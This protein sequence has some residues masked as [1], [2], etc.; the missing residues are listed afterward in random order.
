MAW[1]RA[2]LAPLAIAFAAGIAA[3]PWV[4][5]TAAWVAGVAA[6]VW[7]T[8]LVS[9]GRLGWASAFLL[10]GVAAAGVLR[11]TPLPP[12][13]DHVARLALPVAARLE[14]RLAREPVRFAPERTRLLV[15]AERVD[16]RPASG[17][18]QVTVYGPA[19]DL[20]E[21]QRVAAILRL[22][23]ATGFRNP[24]GFDHARYLARQGIFVVG[25]ADAGRLEALD[26]PV[27]PWPARA[28]RAARQ[29]I[30]ASLPPASAAVLAG[31]LFGDRADLPPDLDEAFRR[32]GV[33]H[34]LAVSGSNVALVAGAAFGLLALARLGRRV[35]AVGAIAAVVAFALV[36]GPDPSVLR[37]TVMGVLVLGALLLDR[38][39][40]VLNAVALAAL[41]ILAG[42]PADLA[43]PGFQLS[44]A[45]TVAIV[46]AP[47]PRGLVG[48]ALGVAVAAQLAVLPIA[49]AHFNQLTPLAPL[50]NLGVVPLAGLAT[51]VGLLAVVVS[52]VSAPAG[53]VLF[54]ATWPV[55]LGL[56]GLVAAFAALPGAL[57]RL[58]APGGPALVLYGLG[59]GLALGW[60]RLRGP[61][62]AR[63]TAAGV[64][65]LACL[66][67]AV[68]LAAWPLVRPSDGRLRVTVLDVGQ[69]D[70]I[71]VETPGGGAVLVDAGPGGP[72]RLDTGERVVAPF[73]WNRGVRRLALAVTTHFDLDHAGGMAWV[74]RNFAVAERWD[75]TALP[76]GRRWI[77]GVGL[78]ALPAD[79]PAGRPERGNTR[80][81]ALRIDHGLASFLLASDLEAAAEARLLAAGA[82]L[83]ATVL[84]VAHHGAAGSSTPEFLARV[85]PRVTV[86]SVGP[87]NPYGHPAPAV[88][89]RL[90]G[91]GARTYRTDRDG[92]VVMETDGRMLRVTAWASGRTD[93]YCLD[94]EAG[95]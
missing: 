45:A 82:P 81:L 61:R 32:A 47:I 26:A 91:A 46:L 37:A 93:R 59:L 40:S 11:A 24:G 70:A 58:P 2:P 23:R 56:R 48:G 6:L 12:P 78:L 72:H 67:V 87:R 52:A 21:G 55:L 90:A 5:T 39:S 89:A 86:V 31:L 76:G 28:R 57:V 95:C 20:V 42:R 34:V 92:A 19:P 94:P 18:V 65:G 43:D 60:W 79:G 29:A 33:Y 16:D 71:V 84:K 30:A 49:L 13:A 51:V 22:H 25:A 1:A 9:L 88:L 17:R 80:A 44:F 68:A 4:A 8:S 73:L 15:D 35:A 85:A 50:A 41:L 54:E 77:G 75:P 53:A 63:A 38:E 62:P 14:G 7:G 74:A 69:G 66:A 83:A 3:A 10:A 27:P 36:A 64:G